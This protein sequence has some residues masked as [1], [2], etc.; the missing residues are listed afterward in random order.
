[1]VELT[2]TNNLN[3][4]EKD[5]LRKTLN[6][7]SDDELI[8]SLARI[9]KAASTEYLEMILGKQLPTRANEINE[10]HLFYLLKFYFRGRIP[11]E[12]EVS[13]LFQATHST[14]RT[15]LRNVRTK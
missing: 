8:I 11:S 15:L 6:C 10:R 14:S 1:M 9:S 4:E 12:A 13:A 2:I 7:S 3:N 5:L